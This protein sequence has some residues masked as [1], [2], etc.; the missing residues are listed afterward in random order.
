MWQRIEQ[1]HWYS[2]VLV[3]AIHTKRFFTYPIAWSVDRINK[4]GLI[5]PFIV[6]SIEYICTWQK[7][8]FV[9]CLYLISWTLGKR[10]DLLSNII[11]LCITDFLWPM[12]M[13]EI[14][15]TYT[16]FVKSWVLF[17]ARTADIQT[18]MYRKH[19]IHVSL[20][21]YFFLCFC[22][23]F[24]VAS[25]FSDIWKVLICVHYSLEVGSEAR[26]RQEN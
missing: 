1:Q 17:I 12:K 4:M 7:I 18:H 6:F 24:F 22:F 20:C 19:V 15:R 11:R 25:E 13:L 16:S 2:F 8:E 5:N 3:N 26:T 10:C 14:S 23:C 21:A 9:L